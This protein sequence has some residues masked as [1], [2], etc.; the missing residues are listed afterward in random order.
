MANNSTPRISVNKLAEYI[1]SKG[2]RQRQILRDQKFPQD[3]KGMYYKE[4]GEAISLCIA[5]NLEDQS[6]LERAL[7][8]LN[9]RTPEKIGT[10]RRIS[11]NI[12]A[13][14][15]FMSMLDQ[16]DLMGAKAILGNNSAP[17]ISRFGVDIS[18]RPEIVLY[19]KGKSGKSLAG[20][21]KLHFPRTFPLN[22]ESAGYVSALSQEYCRTHLSADHEAFGP[23][24]CVID[25]G[26][27]AVYPGVKA[28][29]MRMRDIDSECRN[30][31]AI[32]PTITAAD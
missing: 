24:C 25:V 19:G 9:Q 32:W 23:Y 27:K 7:L 21:L 20:A 28:T 15:T 5:S 11:A 8:I 10:A 26:S 3:Y 13:I 2:N 6:S 30:I 1:V 16:V 29:A 31:A 12:D 14:E 22:E 17:K 18:I 4:A